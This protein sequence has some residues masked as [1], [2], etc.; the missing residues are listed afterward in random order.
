MSCTAPLEGAL[1]EISAGNAS[2]PPRVAARTPDG[3]LAAMPG[4]VAGI[5]SAVKLVSVFPG[6]SLAACP[7]TKR[8]SGCSTPAT[9][10]C[11][12]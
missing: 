12:R 7:P 11:S 8:S 2:V 3:L 10:A 1:R 4:Y 9:V 6:N 5:G